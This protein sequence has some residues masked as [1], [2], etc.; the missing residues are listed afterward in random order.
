M[1]R[2]P[3]LARDAA[4]AITTASIDMEGLSGPAIGEKLRSERR[5]AV[6]AVLRERLKET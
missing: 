5:R 2:T 1:L 4:A 6:A 3:F